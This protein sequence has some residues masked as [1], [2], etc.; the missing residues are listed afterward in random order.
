MLKVGEKLPDPTVASPKP[1]LPQ[2]IQNSVEMRVV[3]MLKEQVNKGCICCVVW[4]AWYKQP[5]P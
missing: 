4:A 1:A 3:N 5:Y 2:E